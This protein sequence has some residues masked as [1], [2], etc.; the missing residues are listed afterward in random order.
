MGYAVSWLAFRGNTESFVLSSLGLE[1]TGGTEE[2]PESDWSTT[3]VRDWMIIWSN[4]YEPKRFHHAGSKLNGEVI[5]CDVEEHVMFVSVA[6]L[7]NGTMNWRIVH[8]AQQASDHLLVEGQPPESL[9]RIQSE[10][11][12]R[13]TEDREVDFIFDIPVRIAQELVGFRHDGTSN[14]A[15][16]V[17]RSLRGTNPNGSFW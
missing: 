12:A 5:I 4:A 2:I 9:A 16:E 15:F 7:K 17:L 6:A 11:F 3:R 10:Q 1:K 8:D 13:V 14:T